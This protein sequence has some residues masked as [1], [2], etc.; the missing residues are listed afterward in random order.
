M[1]IS[2]LY[3][4]N[5]PVKTGFLLSPQMMN[6]KHLPHLFATPSP[7]CMTTMTPY[8]IF[9]YRPVPPGKLPC[10]PKWTNSPPFPRHTNKH[11]DSDIKLDKNESSK[12]KESKYRPPLKILKKKPA[13]ARNPQPLRHSVQR[14]FFEFHPLFVLL[15]FQVYNMSK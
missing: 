7:T 8:I 13:F 9:F 12:L 3:S 15:T 11:Q 5:R 6:L 14:M 4:E 10:P 1:K 2:V